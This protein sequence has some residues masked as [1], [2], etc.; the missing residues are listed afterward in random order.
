MDAFQG[1][2]ARHTGASNDS[3]TSAAA[4]TMRLRDR[5]D[6]PETLQSQIAEARVII[7]TPAQRPVKFSV[8]GSDWQIVDAGVAPT[9]VT[10]RCEFPILVAVAAVPMLGIIMPFIGE[11][12][13]NAIAGKGPQLFDESVVEFLGPFALQKLPHLF[14]TDR[15]LRAIAPARVF[16]VDEHDTLRIASI[17]RVL[18]HAYLLCCTLRSKRWKG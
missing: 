12:H 3:C 6:E 18:G 14:A 9:H 8:R 15:K 11:S 2:S 5:L 1:P 16:G 4:L 17:P 13:A 10:L 7:R